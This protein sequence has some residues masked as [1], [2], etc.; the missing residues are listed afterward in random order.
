VRFDQTALFIYIM[1]RF[2]RR[3]LSPAP[4]LFVVTILA[5]LPHLLAQEVSFQHDVR[6]ILSDKCFKCHGFDAKNQESDFRV[7]TFEEATRDL[8]GYS[9]V[10]P[11]NSETSELIARIFSDDPTEVMPTPKSKLSLNEK[12]KDI[13]KR[14]IE[15]GAKY[16][17]HWAFTELPSATDIP[18]SGKAET[19]T[20]IDEFIF[21]RLSKEKLEPAP[22]VAREK[23]LRRVSFDLTGLPPTLSELDTFLADSSPNAYEKQVDRLLS[24]VAYAERL[25]NEWL[26]VA[27]Y[28]DSYGYQVDRDR[29]VWP[30]RDWVIRSF[31]KNL[32]YNQFI[33]HQ[34]AG[35]LLPNASHETRIA[36]TFNRL[37]G[38]KI[39]GG[40][41]EEEFRQEYIADRA[42]T[43][44][45]AF[46]GLT[47]ECSKCHDH[48][49]DPITQKDYYSLS[50]FFN[51]I[52][53]SGVHAYFYSN[54]TPTP[55]LDLPNKTQKSTLQA[56]QKN[57]VAIEKEIIAAK[58]AAIPAFEKWLTTADEL[59]SL[60]TD[61]VVHIDFDSL[62]AKKNKVRNLI[63]TE[64]KKLIEF[65]ITRNT[66]VEGP[67]SQT[68]KFTGDNPLVIP[69]KEGEFDR[70]QPFTYSLSIY[71]PN[72]YE[73]A[74]LLTRG[75]ATLDSA[76]RGQL[77][78][79]DDGRL[80]AS[81]SHFWPGN[82]ARIQ[83][84]EKLPIKTW[85]HL[86]WTYDGSSQAE[87]MT[88]FLNGK[89]L[90]TKII[91]NQLTR[92]I[93]GKNNK[94]LNLGALDRDKGFKAGQ[95]DNFRLFT[96]ALAP[97]EIQSLAGLKTQPKSQDLE[98]F[99]YTV[100]H[101]PT[102]AL[103]TKLQAARKK[104]YT[105]QNKIPQ[106]MTMSEFQGER[107]KHHVLNRGLYSEKGE[108]VQPN[109]P[110]FL[111]SLKRS[112]PSSPAT[113]LDLANWL[114]EPNNPLTARVTVN[115]YW[116]MFFGKGLVASSE[117]FGN[118]GNIP[119]H[120]ELLNWLA[121][122]F[123]EHDWNLHHLFKKIVLSHT[124][125][126]STKSSTDLSTLDPENQLLARASASP[127]T[128]EMI[129]DNAL[130]VSNLLANKV[131]GGPVKPYDIAL[132][133]G[134]KGTPKASSKG[135]G[136]YR[137]SLY[138]YW[139][140]NGPSP[141]MLTLDAAKRSICTVRR[142]K[143]SSPLQSLVLLN[144]PQFV[145]A[146]RATAN[147]LLKEENQPES[148]TKKAFR[149]TTS[150][151]PNEKEASILIQLYTEQLQY[152]EEHPDEAKE[153]INVGNTS[154]TDQYPAPQLA[155]LTALVSAL[156]NFDECNRS[157]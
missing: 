28:S 54:A 55:A 36:T 109:T 19:K 104:L 40:S 99:F 33:T 140:V 152:F 49:Y 138:T 71:L 113:R 129:R 106:I 100:I 149:L 1:A 154:P 143:T 114:T 95:F 139:K 141:L 68:I 116:Q 127:L 134:S 41:I 60:S 124:Y 37:H 21:E 12:E 87:G 105:A 90:P 62:N 48:K 84:V 96:R 4:I 52:D 130:A 101:E 44:G 94:N 26:D 66:L 43:V 77:L 73:R 150:R 80:N 147:L 64:E 148:F 6:P 58:K 56:A 11:G 67:D 7:H 97:N 63:S 70:E 83:T 131:G 156:F 111:P 86:A 128:A 153:Y 32:P 20:E 98:A 14:W 92:S 132:A 47:M 5:A 120:P 110:G 103:L 13:L 115:R 133:F 81:L 72:E 137:R 91:R 118:Q 76:S 122:D 79:I 22:E 75:K 93:T 42:N 61:Q 119:T 23:W 102:K 53:E 38:Q 15:Q 112:D 17:K 85:H 3:M 65:P 107:K 27:R 82:T 50:A 30:W 142:E 69:Q 34:L 155:A 57:V 8:G 123:I 88:L 16:E 151:L 29:R 35:D 74:M 89:K 59:S 117:D 144:S 108:E 121:R 39:E 18:K 146:A 25:T 135:E 24:T 9:G 45:T 31:Q 46:M 136:L 51:N 2:N 157:Y 125:R 78:T 126:Q 10:V 145:E